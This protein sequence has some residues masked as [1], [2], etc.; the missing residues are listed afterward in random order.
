MTAERTTGWE[1]ARDLG[2]LALR[3]TLGVIF[4]A[5]GAQKLFG[6][7]GGYGWNATLDYFATQ[8]GVP[9]PLGALA[10]LTEFFGGAAVLLGVFSRLAALGLAVTM[11]V[12]AAKAHLANGFFINWTNAAGQG[13]GI[14]M[15]LALFGMAL[16]V[17]LAGPGRWAVAGDTERVLADRLGSQPEAGDPKPAVAGGATA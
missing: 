1:T 8:M 2:Y 10:I 13:H 7:F 9:A 14:E 16:L 5:H 6:W 17:L 15:N 11:V 3:A 12:A 4:M